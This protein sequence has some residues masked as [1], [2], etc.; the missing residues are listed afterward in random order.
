MLKQSDIVERVNRLAVGYT[1]HWDDI[2]Y[3]ADKAIIKINDFLG[4][5][6]RPCQNRSSRSD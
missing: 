4:L 2:K 5:T 3:D 6:F 1:V